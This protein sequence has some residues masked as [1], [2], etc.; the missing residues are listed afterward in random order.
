[1]PNYHSV[2]AAIAWVEV[3]A[4]SLD[5]EDVPPNTARERVLT[6]HIRVVQPIPT[7][8]R[9]ALDG[10]AVQASASLGASP[11]NPVHLPLI[12]VAAGDALPPGPM[13]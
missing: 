6:A 5:A 3:F 8:D 9:A 12:A 13:R 4:H 11:Y 1:L 10:F 7:V 2:D